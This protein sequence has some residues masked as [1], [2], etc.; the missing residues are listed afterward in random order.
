MKSNV[1]LIFDF[2]AAIS[3]EV[4]IVA[5]KSPATV[6]AACEPSVP[7]KSTKCAGQKLSKKPFLTAS[8]KHVIKA[9][10][11][12]S[13]VRL[14]RKIRNRIAAAKYAQPMSPRIPYQLVWIEN[15]ASV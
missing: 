2:N 6:M 8:K 15:G 13:A 10:Q 12:S 9:T 5:S 7:P 3:G 1:N 11:P 4:K 14:A